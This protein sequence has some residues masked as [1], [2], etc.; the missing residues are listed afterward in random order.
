M[1]GVLLIYRF[2]CKCV[3]RQINQTSLTIDLGDRRLGVQLGNS[4]HEGPRKPFL[5]DETSVNGLR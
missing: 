1:A 3:K 5:E 4:L 2:P